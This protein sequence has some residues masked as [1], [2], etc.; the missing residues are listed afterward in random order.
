[1]TKQ[2]QHSQYKNFDLLDRVDLHFAPGMSVEKW[3][4]RITGLTVYWAN[5]PSPLL[6]SYS[7][8]RS[9]IFNDSGV[10]HTLEH[11]IFLGS[12]KYPFKGVLDTLA[13]RAFAQGTNAWTAQDH[14][15]YT[16]TTAG[17][18]GFLRMLPVYLDHVFH[19]TLTS[20]G[21]VTE[22]YHVNGKGEDAGVVFSEMQGRENSSG[23]LMQLEFQRNLYKSASGYRSETGGLMSALRILTIDDIREYHQKYYAPYNTAVVLCGSLD[24]ESMLDSL[25]T[26]E[27]DLVKHGGKG[28]PA[29]WKRPFLETPSAQLPQILEKRSQVVVDF[30]EKDESVGE[31]MIGWV[32]PS[33]NEWE[34][35]EAISVLGTYLTD[36]AVSPVQKALVERDDPQCTD[37]YFSTSDKAGAST[38]EAYFSS[39]PTAVIDKLDS[40]LVDE[41]FAKVAQ[42][43]IDMTRMK[44][45]IDRERTKLLNMLETKPAD[46]LAD[47]IIVDFLYGQENGRDLEASLDSMKQYDALEKYTSSQWVQ[48]L[49]RWFID[50]NRLVI[51]GKPSAQMA[52]RLK[53][54]T[55]DLIQKRKVELGETG[56][57]KL[58]KALQDA[59]KLNDLEIPK[60][61]LSDFQIPDVKSINWI[62]VGTVTEG[63]INTASGHLS[64]RA[65]ATNALD[66]KLQSHLA[67]EGDWQ[68]PFFVQWNQIPSNFIT[69]TIMLNTTSL[70][71]Q[72]RPLLTLFLSSIFSLPVKR[73]DG[74]ELGYEEVVKLLD[75]DTL[76][77]DACLGAGSGFAEMIS[78]EIKVEKTKFLKGIEWIHDLLWNTQLAID[79]LK[80]NAAKLAQS[81]PEQKRDGRTISW[82]LSRSLTH[83]DQL[84]SNL[85]NNI[86]TQSD[87]IPKVVEQLSSPSTASVVIDQ[88]E[89]LRRTLLTPEKIML[90]VAGD[91]TSIQDPKDVLRKMTRKV[92]WNSKP[93][94]TEKVPLSRFVL[95]PLGKTPC[96][97]GIITPLSTLESSFA[98]FSSKGLEDYQ[99][100]DYVALSVTISV[101]NAMESYLWRYIR[102]AG[103]AYGASIRA[104]AEAGLIHF[105]L[106]RSPDSSKAFTAA[107]DVIRQLVNGDMSIGDDVLDSAKSSL[108]FGVADAEGTASLAASE[109]FTDSVLKG[110]GKGRG[111]R[112]LEESNKVTVEQVKQCLAKYIQPI[113]DSTTSI[114][115]IACSPGRLGEMK[116]AL[117]KVG[118]EMEQRDLKLGEE[119]E[120]E[121]EDDGSDS[122]ESMEGGSSKL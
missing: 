43:G 23:D 59:Q 58:D 2:Q 17:S 31:I 16:L 45:I 83:S 119:D 13:N 6:N 93:T 48:V 117:E 37:V 84:S 122:D 106:Y 85:L 27:D 111:R 20:E 19:P 34:V 108:C 91:I 36:S 55:Q 118:Y 105:T 73:S 114:C 75:E 4:S 1:M 26:T 42:D 76:E 72:L 30:P 116:A 92:G 95:T 28:A 47:V 32:G 51:S 35:Q 10:P 54:E 53:K 113:F 74:T 39:V 79:R 41:V 71:A 8:I 63:S 56:L 121:E 115:A 96:R 87:V 14:T 97:K 86:L 64:S 101:L 99:D 65:T 104:D 62:E 107:A 29:G 94:E 3:K 21:F 110:T 81:L 77:Y 33:V 120:T 70:S 78:V 66:E 24:S 11:L 18:D 69:L 15:A 103:L 22:V 61:M 12:E 90:T 49:R 44:T 57:A 40:T 68:P 89:D 25:Q 102:G 9:E 98:V 88:L 50:N 38:L 52:D 112:L 82:A 5:F 60:K 46:S 109:A 80:V 67:K 7:A 100:P